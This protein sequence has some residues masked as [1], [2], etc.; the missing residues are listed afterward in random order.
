MVP[1]LSGSV[2]A[3]LRSAFLLPFSS[4][5]SATAAGARV[6]TDSSSSSLLCLLPSGRPPAPSQTKT[7]T[8]RSRRW[9]HFRR[10]AP[11]PPPRRCTQRATPLRHFR[12]RLAA[13]N[14]ALSDPSPP[15]PGG[16]AGRGGAGR[17]S[18]EAS[19]PPGRDRLS[20]SASASA[21]DTPARVPA[22]ASAIVI[23]AGIVGFGFRRQDGVSPTLFCVWRRPK[24]FVFVALILCGAAR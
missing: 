21:S 12:R 22:L 5:S 4:S 19:E 6:P 10:P 2:S 15:G 20:A 3:S 16:G 11:T 17:L 9:S 24:A 8:L 7:Q 14:T 23:W 1:P 18:R 13:C